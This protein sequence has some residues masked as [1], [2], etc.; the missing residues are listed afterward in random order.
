M[1]SR[2]SP[3][4][5]RLKAAAPVI[6][7]FAGLL[8]N[9]STLG[10]RVGVQDFWV[11]GAYELLVGGLLWWMS[12]RPAVRPG[13]VAENSSGWRRA[14]LPWLHY[15]GPYLAVQFFFGSLFSALFILYSKSAGHLGSF[16]LSFALGALLVANEFLARHYRYRYT[17]NW[18]FFGLTAML[19][20]NFVLPYTVGSLHPAWFYLSTGTGAG[21]AH[22]LRWG[23]P[24]R[25]GR[26]APVWGLAVALG[27]ANL[28]D[29]IPP[30]PLVKRG[31]LVGHD[32]QRASYQI[33]VEKAPWW[34]YW[35]DQS[36]VVHVVDGERLY[37]L[38]SVFAPGGLGTT[39]SHRW[40]R[41]D[42]GGRWLPVQETRFALFGG[43]ENGFRGFSYTSNPRPG[44]WRVL[45]LSEGGRVLAVQKFEVAA[46]AP[47]AESLA[48]RGL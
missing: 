1:L 3:L 16:A 5:S 38:S 21:L 43:R 27:L 34:A 17:L 32:L 23:T 26:I 35:L 2:S 29:I 6:S 40:E 19:L 13:G 4:I 39:L 42:A 33:S 25:P 36:T 10:R 37:C 46:G 15:H 14:W 20:L 44:G 30:V 11:L 24:G 28:L 9:V 7:F 22:L 18:A 47:V 12:H 48:L 41:E 45:L 8:W 31:M